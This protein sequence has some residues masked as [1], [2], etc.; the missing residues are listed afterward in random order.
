MAQHEV[1]DQGD[2]W[3]TP[4]NNRVT[5]FEIY[6]F[7]GGATGAMGIDPATN[8]HSVAWIKW[9]KAIYEKEDLENSASI[10]KIKARCP[11]CDMLDVVKGTPGKPAKEMVT[12]KKTI[13]TQ[14]YSIMEDED[15]FKTESSNKVAISVGELVPPKYVAFGADLIKK[16]VCTRLGDII[17]TV[18]LAAATDLAAGY[19]SDPGHKAACRTMSNAMIDNINLCPEDQEE[20]KLYTKKF[21]EA[22]K[23]QGSLMNAVKKSM[24]K[25]ADEILGDTGVELVRTTTKRTDTR[26]RVGKI[27]PGQLID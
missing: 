21:I 2:V 10:T 8:K 19:A 18:F 26:V 3:L 16:S 12:A 15:P 14:D 6:P 11:V 13:E 25:S 1:L 23:E 20:L 27:G 22:Y 4:I 24:F 9:P 17:G 5:S 7:Q